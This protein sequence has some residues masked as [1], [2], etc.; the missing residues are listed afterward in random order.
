MIQLKQERNQL[1]TDIYDGLKPKR[2]PIRIQV[3]HEAAIQ[4]CKMDL[5]HT[6]W[7]KTAYFSF[8][9]KVSAQL[10]TDLTPVSMNVRTPAYYQILESEAFVMSS[11]GVLQHPEVKSMEA[12]EYDEFIE[13]PYS[14]ILTKALPRVYKGFGGDPVRKSLNLAKAMAAYEDYKKAQLVAM[15]KINEKYGYAHLP[16]GGVTEA[17][18]D[19]L[20]DVLRS[21]T[22]ISKDIRRCPDKIAEACDAVLPYLQRCAVSPMSS[23]YNRTM[24]PVHMPPFM[25]TKQ[26]EKYF[27]PSFKQL[28]QFIY[29]RGSN[30]WLLL[31]G[32]MVRY[33][34]YINELPGNPEVRHEYGD[35]K[36][37]LER[38]NKKHIISGLYP[39]TM[40]ETSSEKECMDYARKT[41][42]ILGQNGNYIFNFD[43]PILSLDENSMQNLRAV[44]ATVRKYG[45]Y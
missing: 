23:N 17:P 40:L 36:E 44:I 30:C 32:D 15:S 33:I 26:F 31:Q 38:T 4:Y 6:Q 34:D 27:W 39:V 37:V 10:E 25:N 3:T 20:A 21:F 35:M 24:I 2:I 41:V 18:Y 29:E 42:E 13:D 5:K 9:D 7:D 43:K 8:M 19:F 45:E 14:F 1:F 28:V 11:S 22:E 16:I 12:K